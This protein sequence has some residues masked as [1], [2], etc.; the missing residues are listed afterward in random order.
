MYVSWYYH[1]CV[2]ILLCMCPHATIC[3][4]TNIYVSSYYYVCVLMLLSVLIQ[5]YVS[6]YYYMCHHATICVL[7]LLHMCPHTTIVV[8]LLFVSSYKYVSSCC[9]MCPHNTIYLLPSILLKMCLHTTT[10]LILVYTCPH[11]TRYTIQHRLR[12]QYDS[13]LSI[14]TRV[15]EYDVWGHVY[16]SYY[17][18]TGGEYDN[19]VWVSE[20]ASECMCVYT[21]TQV[22]NT[23]A[24]CEWVSERA[25]VYVY[26]LLHR[27]RIR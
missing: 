18:Y 21:T 20:R 12:I 8:I 14:R 1:A 16:T 26:I 27:W 13:S 23:I 9:Y 19:S 4:H 22:A 2:L 24:A 6:S 25:S 17:Y 10:Y 7:I 5:I 3:P 15:H 11:A